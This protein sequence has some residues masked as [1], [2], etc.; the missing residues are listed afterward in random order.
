MVVDSWNVAKVLVH[1]SGEGE[2]LIG[3]ICENFHILQGSI[4]EWKLIEKSVDKAI[5]SWTHCTKREGDNFTKY[6]QSWWRCWKR[7]IHA[8]KAESQALS[9]KAKKAHFYHI[10]HE[11]KRSVCWKMSKN[12]NLIGKVLPNQKQQLNPA[13]INFLLYFVNKWE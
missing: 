6:V 10:N 12:W 4:T 5:W 1:C 13:M 2:T 3:I 9:L 8:Q 7:W 11:W